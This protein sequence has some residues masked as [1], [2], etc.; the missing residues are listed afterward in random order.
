MGSTKIKLD[1]DLV[2]RA[3]AFAEAE[4]YSD[5]EE[6]MAHAI[7]QAISGADEEEDEAAVREKLQGLGYIS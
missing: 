5:V 6:F 4:G 2:D 1:S 7:E 3:K